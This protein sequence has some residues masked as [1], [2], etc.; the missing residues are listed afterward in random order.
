MK[1]VKYFVGEFDRINEGLEN[2]SLNADNVISI[3]PLPLSN[4]PYD[5][6]QKQQ[7]VVYYKECLETLNPANQKPIHDL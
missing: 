4:S 7:V 2:R 5:I 3:I 6:G 1:E